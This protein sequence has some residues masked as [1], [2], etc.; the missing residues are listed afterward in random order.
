MRSVAQTKLPEGCP[1]LNSYYIYLT[2]SCNLACQH[3]WLSPTFHPHGDTGDS[4]DYELFTLA[5]EEGLP[6]GLKHVKLTGGEPFLHPDFIR[7]IDFLKEKKLPLTIET[8]GTLLNKSLARYLKDR[9]TLS[10]ISV[11]LDGAQAETHD[12]FR[13]VEGS[14]EKACQGIRYLAEA[15]Y[16][17]QVIMSLYGGNVR[18]IEELLRLAEELGAGSVKFNIIQP[19]GRG[20]KVWETG[21]MFDISGLIEIGGWV[22]REL[23]KRVSIPLI[24]DWPMAFHSLRRFLNSNNGTCGILGILGILPTG[25]LA[26]CGIGV[27]IPELSYGLLGEDRVSEVWLSNPILIALRR[28]LPDG[29]EGICGN[30]IFRNSCLGKCIA[31]NY[32][33]GKR[34][35]APHW[36]CK[37]ADEAG[38]FP[39]SRLRTLRKAKTALVDQ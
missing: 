28:N 31:E 35:T 33:F 29:L 19:A 12:A 15:G 13:G 14:F 32:S 9:S 2:G 37:I 21:K 1:S 8:N 22:E 26:M 5:I 7:I 38:L 18:E 3:C 27:E 23:Q 34:L 36:F 4:L 17:P 20:R 6:L 39:H 25:K 11:S 10:H 30:C 16:R 24:Y